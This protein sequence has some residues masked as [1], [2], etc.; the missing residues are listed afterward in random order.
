MAKLA[1]VKVTMRWY[2]WL[3]MFFVRS[4]PKVAILKYTTNLRTAVKFWVSLRAFFLNRSWKWQTHIKWGLLQLWALR[5]MWNKI[6]FDR[7]R[8]VFWS[9]ICRQINNRIRPNLWPKLWR[10]WVIAIEFVLLV[11]RL[12]ELRV[13]GPFRLHNFY[14]K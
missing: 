7:I 10:W 13:T 8:L 2:F 4:V 11:V 1:T 6:I 3:G 9:A 5:L 14:K 12:A